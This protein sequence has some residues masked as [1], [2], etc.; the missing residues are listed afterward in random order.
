MSNSS[1]CSTARRC[2]KVHDATS[3]MIAATTGGVALEH[4]YCVGSM[5]ASR[6]SRTGLSGSPSWA[7]TRSS[8]GR[9]VRGT[10]PWRSV[11]R[12]ARPITSR[13]ELHDVTTGPSLEAKRL[14]TYLSAGLTDESIARRIGRLQEA[15]GAQ[16][17]FQLGVQASRQGWL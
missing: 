2:S 6:A 9:P 16:S 5:A 3:G 17:R 7:Q 8:S 4:S 13:T 11:R 10:A 14:L 12:S 1:T 15:L